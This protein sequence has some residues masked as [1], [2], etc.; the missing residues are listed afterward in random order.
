MKSAA[1]SLILVV[2]IVIFIKIYSKQRSPNAAEVQLPP[3][4]E[5]L[6]HSAWTWLHTM[7]AHYP[8]HPTVDEQKGMAHLIYNFARFYPCH[9]CASNLKSEMRD[10]PPEVGT[11]RDFEGWLCKLHNR[12]NKRLNK[13]TFDCSMSTYR[14]RGLSNCDG[15]CKVPQTSR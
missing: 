15:R 8:D 5:E 14:W 4:V 10:L 11:R 9:E 1:F 3:T 6:G 2:T 12:V 7:A 13:P